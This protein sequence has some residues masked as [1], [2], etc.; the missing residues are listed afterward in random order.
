MARS[1]AVTDRIRAI[2]VEHGRLR[3]RP[4]ALLDDTD[5]YQAGMT[6]HAGVNVMLGLEE[7]FDLEF[8]DAM[9]HRATFASINAIRAAIESLQDSA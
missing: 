2:V 5:L 8:P 3:V 1:T 6:S 4:D 7:A 9:L